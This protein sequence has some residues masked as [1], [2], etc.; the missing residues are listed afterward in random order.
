MSITLIYLLLYFGNTTDIADYF[1]DSTITG[2]IIGNKNNDFILRFP[3][4]LD[5]YT[6]PTLFPII[7]EFFNYGN[8]CGILCNTNKD[9]KRTTPVFDS[10]RNS[11]Y[12]LKN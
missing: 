5:N 2:S 6:D 7:V 1:V 3:Q 4:G 10:F 9:Q 12:S 8:N 11:N